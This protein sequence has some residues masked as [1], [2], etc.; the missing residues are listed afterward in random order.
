MFKKILVALDR[1]QIN[2]Q[3]F[4]SALDLAMKN[5]ANLA[6]LHVLSSEEE[7]SPLMPIYSSLNYYPE[8]AR[9]ELYQKEW[10]EFREEGIKILQHYTN[11][12]TTNNVEAEFTQVLGSPGRTICEFASNWDADLIVVGRRSRSRLAEIFLGSVS[13][14]VLHHAQCS[15]L[16]IEETKDS[17]TATSPEIESTSV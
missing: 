17:S 14:Y 5:N 11:L 6:L 10:D 8:L 1:S 2:Q 16:I 4:E 7:N 9:T 3:V 12:A 13:N 15:I